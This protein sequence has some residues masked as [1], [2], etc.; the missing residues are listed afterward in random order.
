MAAD[1]LP[2]PPV[3]EPPP[4]RPADKPMTRRGCL[5]GIAGWLLLITVPFCLVLFAIRGDITWNRGSLT[6]DRLW[7]VNLAAEPGQ[8]AAAGVAYSATRLVTPAAALAPG[9][10]CARTTVHFFLWRGR[11]ETISYCECYQ[12]R[13]GPQAGLQSLGACP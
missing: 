3:G 2:P 4:A 7:L 9:A 11:S 5:A 8:E 12:P 1:N 13:G 10:L 6:Q